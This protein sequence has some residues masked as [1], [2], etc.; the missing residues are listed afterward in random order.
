MSVAVL[1]PAVRAIR[2]LPVP[3]ADPPY[4]DEL[5]TDVVGALAL[6]TT[7]APLDPASTVRAV[8]LRLVPAI[9]ALDEDAHFAPQRTLRAD[10]PD[11][12]AW[13]RT[14]AQAVVEVLSGHRPA[15]QLAGMATMSVYAGIERTVTLRGRRG[16]QER[17]TVVRPIVRSVHVSE[18]ADGV[19]EACAVVDTGTR[20]RAL[21]L[22]IEGVDGR[23]TCTALQSG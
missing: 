6:A 12:V 9:E 19:A 8:P 23:W 11:P 21:A 7:P 22:R 17:R 15:P 16:V 2:R 13:T 20:R 18:P 5:G 4:D 1:D 14:F 3:P 10:L